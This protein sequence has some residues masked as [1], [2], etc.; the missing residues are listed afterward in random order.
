MAQCPTNFA[1]DVLTAND[2]FDAILTPEDVSNLNDPEKNL[3]QAMLLATTGMLNN[4]LDAMRTKQIPSAYT[5]D[6]FK[7]EF[8]KLAE[9]HALNPITA[10]EVAMFVM[11]H[12]ATMTPTPPGPDADPEDATSIESLQN[13][14]ISIDVT[15]WNPGSALSAPTISV[16]SSLNDFFDENMGKTLADGSCATFALL[17][18]AIGGLLTTLQGKVK[19]L[20]ELDLFDLSK[21]SLKEILKSG[22]IE[23]K[24]ALEAIAG[25]L[26]KIVDKVFSK[27]QK[28]ATSI[29]S[30]LG[31]LPNAIQ[32][33]IGK[34][35]QAINDFTS[36]KNKNG[37]MDGIDKLIANMSRFF[38]KM[39]P[40]ILGLLM[41]KLCQIA[42]GIQKAGEKPLEGLIQIVAGI[43]VTRKVMKSES[44]K[45]AK[46]AVKRGATRMDK[47][48]VEEKKK[49]IRKKQQQTSS[50]VN[51][52]A[53]AH[54]IEIRTGQDALDIDLMKQYPKVTGAC[55]LKD[56]LAKYVKD[57]N[58][59]TEITGGVGPIVFEG[60]DMQTTVRKDGKDT[61][62][63]GPAWLNTKSKLWTQVLDMSDQLG[64][65]VT[66]V[67]AFKH[68]TE[69]KEQKKGSFVVI[70]VKE[71]TALNYSKNIIAA[72]RAGV[73]GIGVVQDKI[74]LTNKKG[75]FTDAV[76]ISDA[77][78]F[79]AIDKALV[80]H[81]QDAWVVKVANTNVDGG[82][83]VSDEVAALNA[84]ALDSGVV[85]A[86]ENS[87]GV[88]GISDEENAEIDA[89]RNQL[90]AEG[91][92]EG[93]RSGEDGVSI[94][95]ETTPDGIVNT[96]DIDKAASDLGINPSSEVRQQAL[97]QINSGTYVPSDSIIEAQSSYDVHDDF[98]SAF[99]AA[100][101]EI[102]KG[103][104]FFWRG[105]PYLLEKAE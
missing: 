22:I 40:K 23:A 93:G 64:E 2:P 101:N 28:T 83:A 35:S 84:E 55:D 87:S 43:K 74:V 85:V 94:V 96:S 16:L 88:L 25:Q 57:L 82:G 60:D 31:C 36:D 72:S 45:N 54:L 86:D 51:D 7:E 105:Q 63:P 69:I 58:T 97:D 56:S 77:E 38:E 24:L 71:P 65:D 29:T 76:G 21:Y 98:S 19:S 15:N 91:K 99:N 100:Y 26:K 73:K 3:N 59:S 11:E 46:Q 5:Y 4:K 44:A 17:V 37:I 13:G 81:E 68:D 12:G 70:K 90:D 50:K 32:N 39:T 6:Q 33:S 75:R 103:G 47:E 20:N 49:E 42:E 95:N 18:T 78:A 8:P 30:S 10:G 27:V 1:L 52:L 9:R 62:T 89:I 92:L 48:Q 14:Q 79:V 61:E 53:V 80:I 34:A 41:F 66:V 102:G 67:E 104:T